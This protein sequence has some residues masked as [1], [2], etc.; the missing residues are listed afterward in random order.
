MN[1]IKQS[2][3]GITTVAATVPTVNKNKSGFRWPISGQGYVLNGGLPAG[4]YTPVLDQTA[5]RILQPWGTKVPTKL[6][7]RTTGYS[8]IQN[9]SKEFTLEK[10][11]GAFRSAEQG[12]TRLLFTY[13]RDFFLGN[14]QIVS[15]LSKRKLSTLSVPFTVIPENKTIPDDVKAAEVISHLL[16]KYDGFSDALIHAMNSI[17]YPV[18][19]IEKT[20]KPIDEEYGDNPYNLR[21]CIR[22]LHPV[23]YN[24]ISYRLPYVPQQMGHTQVVGPNLITT[25]PVAAYNSTGIP[26]DI[27]YDPD[28]WEPNLRFWQ[29]LPNGIIINTPSTMIAPD[30]YRHMIHRSNLLIGI[31]RENFGALGKSLLFLSIMSQLGLDVFLR[32]MQKYGMPFIVAKVDTSQV[33]TVEQ[34]MNAFRDCNILNAIAVNKDAM[35]ELQEMNYNGAAQAHETFLN[36]VNDQISLLISGQTLSSHTKSTGLGSGTANLQASVREDIIQFDRIN[37]NNFLRNH[38]FRQLLDINGIKG[39]CPNIR[40]GS[41]ATAKETLDISTTLKN[42]KMS[43]LEPTDDAVESL[44]TTFGYPIQRVQASIDENQVENKEPNDSTDNPDEL[45]DQ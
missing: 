4:A 12:D 34:I 28:G 30:P 32:C 35:I 1:K 9:L 19:V 40:W 25:T 5:V 21:Y 2:I 10:V 27:V 13:Y 16:N 44:G 22:H 39:N 8:Q 6:L 7:D 11:Q 42:L 23:D 14:G 17:V 43:G 3:T 24:L 33:D 20:F 26:E 41:A 38:L 45:E 29:V 18:S 36:F 15:E 37:L 31:A